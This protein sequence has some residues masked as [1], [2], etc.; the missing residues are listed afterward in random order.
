MNGTISPLSKKRMID[1]IVNCEN[2]NGV[3]KIIME[4][5]LKN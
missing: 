4:E 5:H 1:K 3:E 2:T